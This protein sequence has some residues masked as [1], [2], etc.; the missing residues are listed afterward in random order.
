VPGAPGRRIP[1]ASTALVTGIPAGAHT[2]TVAKFSDARDTDPAQ[3]FVNSL[4]L[5]EFPF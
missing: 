2:I 4:I 3:G 5:L 1:L